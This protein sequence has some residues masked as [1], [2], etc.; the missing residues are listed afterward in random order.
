MS[1]WTGILVYRVQVSRLCH[2]YITYRQFHYLIPTRNLLLSYTW[3]NQCNFNSSSQYIFLYWSKYLQIFSI[4]YTICFSL[5][6]QKYLFAF[7]F[8]YI[9]LPSECNV[10]HNSFIFV[11]IYNFYL[12]ICNS[13]HT[14]C[15]CS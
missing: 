12:F 8:F 3:G 10:M 14:K 2:I 11:G 13:V 5:S 7:F 6:I 15:M 9:F 1:C 4:I